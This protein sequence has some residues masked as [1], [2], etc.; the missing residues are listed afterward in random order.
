LLSYQ[1]GYHAGGPADV[2]KHVALSILLERLRQK[3]KPFC[4]ID[5]YAGD[6]V[7]DLTSAAAEKTKEF[8]SGI[9]RLWPEMPPAAALYADALRVLNPDGA[10]KHYPGSPAIARQALRADD[11]LILNELH[12]AAY[13]NLRRWSGEDA[14]IAPHKRDGLEAMTALTPPAIR[15]GLV[16][17]DPSYEIKTEYT[18]VPEKLQ[19]TLRKW[20][21][22]IYLVWYPVLAEGRHRALLSALSTLDAEVFGCEWTLPNAQGLLGT[23]IVAIN[24]PFQFDTTM[25]D[26]GRWLA[27]KLGGRHTTRWLKRLET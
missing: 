16:I 6:G 15:R 11:R 27:N 2:H 21:E 1:H 20:A 7:Y 14:R 12:P 19:E 25:I 24:P 10:L 23:G 4:V 18:A 13:R 3:D 5:L 22:G 8:E 17:I 9:G 26:A